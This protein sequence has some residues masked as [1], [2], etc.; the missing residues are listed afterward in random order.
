MSELGR[1]R[2]RTIG[3]RSWR[4]GHGAEWLAALLLMAKGYQIL[5]FRLPS[6]AGEIDIL[7]RRGRWLVV[8]EVKHR[9]DLTAA[10]QALAPAQLQRLVAAGEGVQRGRQSL[11]DLQLRIDMVA[12][13]P[14][15]FPRHIQGVGGDGAGGP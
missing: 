9:A 8:V 1:E 6:K 12:L 10:T 3:G 2:R 5:A 7:A 11:R 14:R 15:R 13:A 4:R